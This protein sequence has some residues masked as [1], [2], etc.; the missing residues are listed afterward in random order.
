M[1]ARTT[2]I[3]LVLVLLAGGLG[4]WLVDREQQQTEPESRPLFEN[5]TAASITGFRI[6]VLKRDAHLELRRGSTQREAQAETGARAAA[7]GWRMVD[8]YDYP[9]E[10]PLVA[11]LIEDVVGAVALPSP[12]DDPN[13]LGFDPPQIVLEVSSLVQTQAGE[14]EE[15]VQR[16]EIGLPALNTS[17]VYVRSADGTIWRTQRNLQTSTDRQVAQW[18]SQQLFDDPPAPSSA[19][20][21]ERRGTLR[22]AGGELA[23]D[24]RAVLEPTGW[25]ASE[26]LRAKL[27]PGLVGQMVA[28]PATL[29]VLEFVRDDA[30]GASDLGFAEPSFTLAISTPAKRATIEFVRAGSGTWLAH[31]PERL[32]VAQVETHEVGRCLRPFEELIDLAL[33]R[34]LRRDI[35]RVTLRLG[36]RSTVLEP[37]GSLWRVGRPEVAPRARAFADGERLAELLTELESTRFAERVLERAFEASQPAIELEIETPAGTFGGELGIAVELEDGARGRMFRRLGEDVVLL[38]PSRLAELL[39][40]DVDE[41]LSR[42]LHEVPEEQI[43]QFEI[44]ARGEQRVW[45]RDPGSG[46]YRL[47]TSADPDPAFELLVDRLRVVRAERYLVPGPAQALVDADGNPPFG[48]AFVVVRKTGGKP[49]SFLL[50]ALETPDSGQPD[51]DPGQPDPGQPDPGQP[52]AGRQVYRTNSVRAELAGGLLEDVLTLFPPN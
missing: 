8:P 28:L 52:V 39:S 41:L 24:L 7:L 16:V 10:Y 35:E 31:R 19:I 30:A 9:A 50:E 51:P 13:A 45:R 18:R 37:A 38:A 23:L 14:L 44:A 3:L 22:G 34:V 15:R 36:A 33:T 46:R 27:D 4:L 42:T 25:M 11:R 40:V 49:V 43:T 21:L 5:L 6:D 47:S 1:H 48:S 26:P 29:R 2:W 12:H 20:E 17:A 32:S